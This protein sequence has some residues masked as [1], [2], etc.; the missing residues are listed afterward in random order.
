MNNSGKVLVVDDEAGLRHTLTRILHLAGCE[1]TS[2]ADGYEALRLLAENGYHLVYLDIR[3]PGMNGLETL[4]N[5]RQ[6]APDLPVILLTAYGSLQTALEALRLG[7]TDYLLKPVDPEVLVSR[8]RMV[9]QEQMVEQ[10]KRAIREQIELLRDELSGL[11]LQYPPEGKTP[12]KAHAAL[13]APEERF[14]KRGALI[15]D[16][17]ARRGTLGERV[18]TLPPAT[19]DYLVVLAR[20]APAPVNYQG[21]VTEAQGYQVDASEARD[22]AKYHVHVLRQSLEIDPKKPQRI[23]TARGVGYRLLAD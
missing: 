8:T 5:I 21:L 10:R 6:L 19:F 15:L 17:Q 2:A 4:R 14:F 9:L 18:I 7:A 22:L 11:E 12:A 3:L 20:H 1:V 13:P 16:L 23:H